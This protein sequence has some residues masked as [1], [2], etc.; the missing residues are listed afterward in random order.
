[1]FV[2]S[3]GGDDAA[4]NITVVVELRRKHLAVET[5][6]HRLVFGI[7]IADQ[8]VADGASGDEITR[9]RSLRQALTHLERLPRYVSHA[10]IGDIYIIGAGHRLGNYRLA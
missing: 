7:E 6:V 10:Q 9:I 3:G 1:M 4:G 5:V 8:Q 2:R